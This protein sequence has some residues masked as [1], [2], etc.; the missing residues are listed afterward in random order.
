VVEDID[1]RAPAR[2]DEALRYAV[3][4]VETD[5]RMT[6]AI[7][8]Y[9]GWYGHTREAVLAATKCFCPKLPFEMTLLGAAGVLIKPDSTARQDRMMARAREMVQTCGF[10]ASNIA[11][12]IAP[13]RVI[14]AS[15]FC[16]L[17][18]AARLQI[19]TVP[20]YTLSASGLSWINQKSF[21]HNNFR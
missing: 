19:R 17:G 4:R 5:P 8:R 6:E 13:H 10:F 12:E 21:L 15:R 9:L 14:I 7:A 18:G 16:K 3:A 11:R 2:L 20:R 1:H